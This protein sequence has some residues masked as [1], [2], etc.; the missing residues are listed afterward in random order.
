MVSNVG[1]HLTVVDLPG[2]IS[3]SEVNGDVELVRNLVD[4]YLENP[5][6]I[7]LAVVP[8]T[9]DINTQ[10]IIQRARR[11]DPN[12]ERT[13]GIITK[14]DLINKGTESRV[15]SLTK[16]QDRTRLKHGFFLLKNLAPNEL[17]VNSSFE[18]RQKVEMRFFRSSPWKEQ[19]LDYTRL[20]ISNLRAFLQDLLEKHIDSE[21]PQVR[22]E[23]KERLAS[24][25]AEIK[26]LGSERSSTSQI[27]QYI[28]IF[29]SDFCNL[30]QAASHGHYD[31]Y[32]RVFFNEHSEN[33]ENRLRATIHEKNSG[34]AV[35]LEVAFG[36]V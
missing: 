19:N 14:P 26:A 25:E 8:A 34:F 28:I 18:D 13:V 17:H 20:G 27:R 1:V 5:R 32:H 4:A 31:E 10:D 36:E 11:F 16:N 2:L 24:T 22:N 12:S 6:S 30:A 7:I 21:L 9:S 3:V 33:P 35:G 29:S 23:I 15:M